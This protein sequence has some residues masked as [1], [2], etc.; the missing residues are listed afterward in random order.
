MS[1]ESRAIEFRNAERRRNAARVAAERA[2][3]GNPS[4]GRE[5]RE[6]WEPIINRG[7]PIP[8]VEDISTDEEDCEDW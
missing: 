6:R 1:E 7:I 2:L 3:R 5:L 8:D 4:A